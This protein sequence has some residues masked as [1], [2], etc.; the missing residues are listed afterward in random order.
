MKYKITIDKFKIPSNMD[1]E[2]SRVVAAIKNRE[3]ELELA[4]AKLNLALLKYQNL[5]GNKK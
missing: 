3:Y 4:V 2:E 5:Y 1:G